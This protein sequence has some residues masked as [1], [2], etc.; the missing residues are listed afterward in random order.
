M[1]EP[2]KKPAEA[3]PA[4]APAKAEAPAEKPAEGSPAEGEGGAVQSAAAVMGGSKLLYIIV[5]SVFAVNLL[6]GF[7]IARF[8]LAPRIEKAKA[9]A[10]Q[11][12]EE[13]VEAVTAEGKDK[14]AVKEEKGKKE[15]HAK[16]GKEGGKEGEA[17]DEKFKIEEM[18]V[19]I[20]GTRGT[21]F[22]RVAMQFDGPEDVH[23][24]LEEIRPK[25]TDI[26]STILSGKR[27]E[28]LETPEIRP[29][30]R[31]EIKILVNAN[32]DNGQVTDIY[33]TDFVI[34]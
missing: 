17:K 34:Q 23:G 11:H 3:T 33:F 7:A 16:G 27:M 18:V 26:V 21:R 30:L 19:N 20:A 1:A 24:K 5:G 14:H 13:G 31:A 10:M 4:A 29:R 2:E 12:P 22:L 8:M 6:S 9:E 15:E 32:L 25:V 28:D